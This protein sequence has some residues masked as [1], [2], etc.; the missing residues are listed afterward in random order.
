[1]GT[2]WVHMRAELAASRCGGDAAAAAPPLCAGPPRQLAEARRSAAD[3]LRPEAVAAGL[4]PA[5]LKEYSRTGFLLLPGRFTAHL[6]ALRA[7]VTELLQPGTVGKLCPGNPRLDFEAAAAGWG[8]PPA[9]LVL[10]SVEPVLDISPGLAAV[11]SSTDVQSIFRSLFLGAKPVLFEDK[12]HMKLPTPRGTAAAQRS[13]ADIGAFPAHQD[14]VFWSTYSRR[15]ATLV[16]YLDDATEANGALQLHPYPPSRGALPHHQPPA[17]PEQQAHFPLQLDAS[18]IDAT[19]TTS[20]LPAGSAVLFDCMTPH[21]SLP[22]VSDTPRRSLFLSYNPAEDGDGYSTVSSGARQPLHL[23]GSHNL[24]HLPS[25]KI[26]AWEAWRRAGELENWRTGGAAMIWGQQD[27]PGTRQYRGAGEQSNAVDISAGTVIA[28]QVDDPHG[29]A[30]CGISAYAPCCV[31]LWRHQVPTTPAAAAAMDGRA[32]PWSLSPP[33]ATEQTTSDQPTETLLPFREVLLP[34]Q[35]GWPRSFRFEDVPPGT[36]AVLAF[37]DTRGDRR[38]NPPHTH[39]RPQP[40]GWYSTGSSRLEKGEMDAE[41]SAIRLTEPSGG[42][43]RDALTPPWIRIVLRL[44][45]N[46]RL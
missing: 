44:P 16:I 23:V 28:G 15:L 37:V 42:S 31:Q 26:A 43:T 27:Q 35:G 14:H 39:G 18:S 33:D 13:H 41:V 19:T 11:A 9:Q 21:A 4:R 6:P 45:L 1:M 40:R 10:K 20:A 17:L 36:Y 38:L 24:G 5:Q 46:H 22:N 25:H 3:M 7:A 29:E 34:D 12:V 32:A 30:H 2:C 8:S